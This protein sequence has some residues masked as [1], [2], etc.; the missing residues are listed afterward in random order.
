MSETT[1]FRT[2]LERDSQFGALGERVYD[3]L[4]IGGGI[5]GAGVARDAVMRGLTVA[6]VE[7]DDFASGTSSRSSRL[8]HGGVR[9]LEHGQL[10]LV[11]EASRERRRLLRIAPHL[12][13]PLRFLWPVY[14]DARMPAWKLAAGL[15]AYDALALFRNVGRHK[16]LSLNGVLREEPRV[17]RTGLLAG[18][19]YWDASTDDARLTLTNILDAARRG[20]MVLNHAEVVGLALEGSR[21]RA[22]VHDTETGMV[23][24]ARAQTVVNASGPWSDQV[25]A[26]VHSEPGASVR[27][28]KGVHIS[29][30]RA[31]IGNLGALTLTAPQDGR[32]MFVLPAGTLAIIGTTD[33]FDDVDPDQVRASEADVQYLLDAANHYFPAAK[34]ARA[35]VVS[36]WAGVRPLAARDEHAGDAGAVSREHAIAWTAPGLLQVTGGKLTTYRAMAAQV[37]DTVLSEHAWRAVPTRTAMEPLPGG[38]ITDIEGE[39]AA[40][41]ALG[42]DTD[43]AER[44]VHAYGSE[45]RAVWDGPSGDARLRERIVPGLPHVFAAL[46]HAVEH[47]L[48]RT[49]ADLLIR[50]VPLAFE[51]PDHGVAAARIAAPLMAEWLGWSGDETASALR[52]YDAEAARIFAIE[53][54]GAAV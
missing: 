20:A 47:E 1:P 7:K 22:Q 6:L 8:V 27:G 25:E 39:I 24:I 12:V 21:W 38:D 48:G 52:A 32:V 3:V 5:T 46:R 34:L 23:A 18:A 10:H 54:S 19:S 53:A 11:F 4:V 16:R 30:E 17:S 40:A 43:I 35:D 2:S 31:R 13:R 51:T 37:V 33:T 9:Y 28:S 36:A 15:T 42:A 41:A 45:W 14:K 49:L 50:R 26:L 44:L 29:V